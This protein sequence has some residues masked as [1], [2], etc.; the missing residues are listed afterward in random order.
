MAKQKGMN[1]STYPVTVPCAWNRLQTKTKLLVC[2]ST[3][4]SLISANRRHIVYEQWLC[5]VPSV[6]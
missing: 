1:D 2:S 4:D 3:L 6:F 5:N